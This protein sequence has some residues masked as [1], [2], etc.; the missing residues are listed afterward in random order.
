MLPLKIPD[1]PKSIQKGFPLKLILDKKAVHQLGEN[2]H[3]VYEQFDKIAFIKDAIKG[4]DS[5]TI[6][7]RSGHIAEAVRKHLPDTYSEAIE[8]KQALEEAEKSIC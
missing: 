7:E 6:T 2:L 3:F 8:I 5:L 4:I 1:A